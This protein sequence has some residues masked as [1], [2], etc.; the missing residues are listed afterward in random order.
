VQSGFP[1]EFAADPIGAELSKPANPSLT[2]IELPCNRGSIAL[3][4]SSSAALISRITV[5]DR[6]S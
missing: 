4:V 3:L 1:R 2:H 6:A 5:L